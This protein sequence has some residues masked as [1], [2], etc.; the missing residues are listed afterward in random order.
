MADVGVHERAD[1]AFEPIPAAAIADAHCSKKA[2][3]AAMCV[4]RETDSRDL[5]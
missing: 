2:G 1:F 3:C 5:R 4:P